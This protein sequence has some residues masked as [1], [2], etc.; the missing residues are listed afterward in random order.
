VV[1]DGEGRGL[2][3]SRL[4]KDDDETIVRTE[5]NGQELTVADESVERCL[6]IN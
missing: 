3:V 4:V 5:R 2:G 1:Y 6:R